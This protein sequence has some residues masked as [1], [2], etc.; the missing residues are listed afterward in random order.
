VWWSDDL[1]PHRAWVDGVEIDDNK[2]AASTMS[3]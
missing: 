1:Q 3:R 2:V